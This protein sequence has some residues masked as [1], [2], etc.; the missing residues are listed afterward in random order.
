MSTAAPAKPKAART[1]VTTRI[2]T[3]GVKAVLAKSA[4]DQLERAHDLCSTLECV[5][6]FVEQAKAAREALR[7]LVDKAS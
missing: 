2:T 6:Q 5:P 4:I 1:I 3:S 7:V